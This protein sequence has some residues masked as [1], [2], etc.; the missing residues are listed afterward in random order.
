MERERNEVYERIPW[1]TLE[2]KG[3]DR[4]WWM[5]ALA[6]AIVLGALAYSYMANRP[7]PASAVTSLAAT[8]NAPLPA[9]APPATL[10]ATPVPDM[11]TPMLVT[12]ADLF[13]VAPERLIERAAAHAEW[14]VAEYVS[15]DGS[16][17]GR[18]ALASLMP[19]GIVV[20]EAT[21]GSRVF[22]EWVRAIGVEEIG[23]Q[24]YRVVVLIRSLLA[25]GEEPYRRQAPFTATVD[26]RI[27]EAGP[28][29]VMPPVLAA[30][31]NPE[32]TPLAL[33]PVP[34]EVEAAATAAS[35]ASA[36]AGGVQAPT[37]EWRV[38]VTAPGP[39]GVLRPS[40]VV[41]PPSS[42]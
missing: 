34:P 10:A 11:S 2:S 7:V 23:P 1:E 8:A 42:P 18:R 21:D 41:V 15:V 12:E 27:T 16:E 38:V 33:V 35:G 36:V 25:N 24:E 6:G 14:F 32:P 22:V 29:V 30:V 37:G 9:A 28:Q 17:E 13:A 26:V 20:P 4:Q 5:F 31:T 19:A 3:G 40:T 39:D